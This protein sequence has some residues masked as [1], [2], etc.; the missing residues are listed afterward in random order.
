ME[1]TFVL[2]VRLLTHLGYPRWCFPRQPQLLRIV[3]KLRALPPSGVGTARQG[4]MGGRND[5]V[6]AVEHM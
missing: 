1:V 3:T 4:G 2:P 5:A 6:V